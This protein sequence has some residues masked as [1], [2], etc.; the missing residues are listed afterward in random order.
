MTACRGLL[1]LFGKKVRKK[2]FLRD[3]LAFWGLFP[4]KSILRDSLAFW[5][6]F[7]KKSIFAGLSGFLGTFS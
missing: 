6:L 3:S 7:P 4:K 5:G 1:G 2:P